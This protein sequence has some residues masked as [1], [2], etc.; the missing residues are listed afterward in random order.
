MALTALAKEGSCEKKPLSLPCNVY[1]SF[2]MNHEHKVN[3]DKT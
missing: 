3:G 2:R 1:W